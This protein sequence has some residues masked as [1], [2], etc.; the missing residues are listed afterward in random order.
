MKRSVSIIGAGRLGKTLGKRLRE[1]GWSV[2]AV[3]TRS[4]ETARAAAR[5]IGGGR[6]FAASDPASQDVVRA[7]D[8]VLIATPDQSMP[9]IVRNLGKRGG[10]WRRTVV[11]HTSGALDH[12]VLA[13]LARLGARTG[14][15]HPMQTFSG[16]HV[17]R[18][19]GVTFTVEGDA[20][21]VRVARS[22]ARSLGGIPVKIAGRDKPAYHMT[23]VLACGGGFPLI[24]A[25]VRVLTRIG[26]TRHRA[27]ATLLPL[28]RQMLDNVERIGPR[29]AWTGPLSRGDYAVVAAHLRAMRGYPPEFRQTYLTHAQLA[30][31]VLA[32]N[33]AAVRKQIDRAAKNSGR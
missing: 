3:V 11:L 5:A 10:D 29:A 14:S 22:I 16:K 7:A 17:P 1:M 33:P 2:G 20:K 31:R 26:F 27:L 19:E 24:E 25:S 30:A 13:P 15:L 32:D 18:L 23:A 9:E 21:A 4:P 6:A 12:S 28:I 8:L